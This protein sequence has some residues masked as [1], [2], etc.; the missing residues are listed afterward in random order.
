MNPPFSDAADIAGRGLG[1]D[2]EELADQ[3]HR[4][5]GDFT[6]FCKWNCHD[7]RSADHLP[8]TFLSFFWIWVWV[9]C[10][11]ERIKTDLRLTK[12]STWKK[13]Q[14]VHSHYTPRKPPSRPARRLSPPRRLCSRWCGF[15]RRSC[16]AVPIL[17]LNVSR[18]IKMYQVSHHHIPILVSSW[19]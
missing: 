13:H 16:R 11:C 12:L 14:P 6:A 10:L 9:W 7:L 4:P 15:H 19:H 17:T 1:S 2:P 3:R 5:T 18:C 8:P